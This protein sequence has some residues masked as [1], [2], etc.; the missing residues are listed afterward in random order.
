M[1]R[2]VRNK[3]SRKE[4][5]SMPIGPM[6]ERQVTTSNSSR[7]VLPCLL[8]CPLLAAS[9]SGDPTNGYS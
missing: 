3:E 2:N 9:K 1:D 6:E 8:L 4:I 7:T 5:Y